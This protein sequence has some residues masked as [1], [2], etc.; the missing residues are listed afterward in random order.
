MVTF[1]FIVKTAAGETRLLSAPTDLVTALQHVRYYQYM[2]GE[3]AEVVAN[4]KQRTR[5]YE[6]MVAK[7]GQQTVGGFPGNVPPPTHEQGNCGGK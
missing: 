5:E 4:T 7:H 3:Q 2:C 1:R 6:A